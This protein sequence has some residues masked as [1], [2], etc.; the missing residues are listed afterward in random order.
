MS[1][2]REDG[3]PDEVR[4]LNMPDPGQVDLALSIQNY[5]SGPDG[6]GVFLRDSWLGLG[7]GSAEAPPTPSLEPE[8]TTGE[9]SGIPNYEVRAEDLRLAW[10]QLA[11]NYGQLPSI[12]ADSAETT[13]NTRAWITSLIDTHN[14]AISSCP[15]VGLNEYCLDQILAAVQSAETTIGDAESVQEDGANEIDELRQE[16]EDFI[17]SVET[18]ESG[19]TEPDPS[20]ELSTEPAPLEPLAPLEPA[21]PGAGTP[22]ASALEPIDLGVGT[23]GAEAEMPG[24]SDLSGDESIGVGDASLPEAAAAVPATS[25][26]SSS[27]DPMMAMMATMLPAMLGNAMQTGLGDEQELGRPHIEQEPAPPPPLTAAATP[28]PPPPAGA[29]VPPPVAT[30]SQTPPPGAVAG[31][32]D[33]PPNTGTPQRTPG[34]DGSV[35]YVFPDGRRQRVSAVVA[36]AL[37]A[38][39][40]NAAETDAQA[41]YA[42]TPAK[43]ND[44]KTIGAAVDPYQLITGD[45]ATWE[46]RT[47]LIVAL[48]TGDTGQLETIVNGQLCIFAAEMSDTSGDFGPFTGF[49]HPNGVEIAAPETGSSAAT[50]SPMEGQSSTATPTS[51]LVQ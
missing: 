15:L 42:Q 50:P 7:E 31:G 19:P 43:W 1:Q 29:A 4:R 30:G 28:P 35:E 38:A 12:I 26:P 17:E 36:E 40:G 10:T 45:V 44:P 16:L 18:G 39:F 32:T 41:A 24:G 2:P 27:M 25:V 20:A 47:A 6:I 46:Q 33:Q 51:S 14:N 5:Y 13:E 49:F 34:P 22:D 3:W 9:G 37:D 11:A 48:N 21:D 23:D 8:I